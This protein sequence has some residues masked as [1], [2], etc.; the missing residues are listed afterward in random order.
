MDKKVFVTRQ[1]PKGSLI[2]YLNAGFTHEAQTGEIPGMDSALTHVTKALIVGKQSMQINQFLSLQAVPNPDGYFCQANINRPLGKF[3]GLPLEES[4][5]FLRDEK[6]EPVLK[7]MQ[8]NSLRRIQAQLPLYGLY[9]LRSH[10]VDCHDNH[11]YILRAFANFDSP[12]QQEEYERLLCDIR[13]SVNYRKDQQTGFEAYNRGTNFPKTE[14]P[15]DSDFWWDLDNDVLFS[16]DKN[17]MTN[18]EQH[19][20]ETFR[21][22]DTVKA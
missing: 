8:L 9:K 18:V 3:E 14:D 12:E 6:S 10:V 21:K 5:T 4:V 17:F 16:F 7:G 20:K 2:R 19:L 11:Q 15:L 1:I 13:D 22:L